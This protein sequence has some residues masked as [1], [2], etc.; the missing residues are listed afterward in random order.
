MIDNVYTGPMTNEQAHVMRRAEKVIALGWGD[1]Y[2]LIA[3]KSKYSK[4]WQVAGCR[5]VWDHAQLMGF[6]SL[7]NSRYAAI[8][9]DK[10]FEVIRRTATQEQT[11]APTYMLDQATYVNYFENPCLRPGDF[12]KFCK[13]DPDFKWWGNKPEY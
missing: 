7:T 13:S 5:E 1:Y 2:N 12:E 6:Y 9:S 8:V 3:L 10:D 4:G 11:V